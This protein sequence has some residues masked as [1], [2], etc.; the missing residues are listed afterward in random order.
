ML[1]D[2]APTLVLTSEALR[3]QLPA[4]RPLLA[5]DAPDLAAV[6][7]RTPAVAPAPRLLPQHPAYVIY[8]SGSTGQP[9]GVV[10][11]H[12]GVSSLAA[13]NER[14]GLTPMARVLQFASWNF[15]ASFWE[16]VM[17]LPAGATLVMLKD[18]TR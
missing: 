15:D 1:A 7:A 10:V 8:T 4:G 6:L 5:L 14:L 13:Q 18:A 2:A 9:K 11:S 17:A 16:F 3:P 12:F